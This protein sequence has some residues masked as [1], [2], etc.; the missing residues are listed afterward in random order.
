MEHSNY[1]NNFPTQ[2]KITEFQK[3]LV[4]QL[5]RPDKL[6]TSITLCVL[7]LTG[8]NSKQITNSQLKCMSSGLRTLHPDVLHLAQ[9]V[10][11]IRSSEPVLLITT[12]GND[13]SGEIQELAAATLGG[14]EKCKEVVF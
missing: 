7:H 4:T 13:P 2:C 5:L 6:H 12:S 11:E 9:I 1:E 14:T 8:K 3:V 10:R